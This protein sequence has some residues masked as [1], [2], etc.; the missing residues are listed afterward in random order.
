VKFAAMTTKR[1]LV[2]ESESGDGGSPTN[3]AKPAKS[4]C[5]ANGGQEWI[6]MK[7]HFDRN[8]F[9][10]IYF[11]SIMDSMSFKKLHTKI[12]FKILIAILGFH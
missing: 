9:G 2:S 1:R 11:L 10:A 5:T 3:G 7:L 8:F 12:N 4:A 6:F